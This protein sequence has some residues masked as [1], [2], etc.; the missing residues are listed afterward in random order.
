MSEG[1][2]PASAMAA[3]P[4]STT[5]SR[6][7]FSCWILCGVF[8]IPRTP[9]LITPPL[10]GFGLAAAGPTVVRAE[11]DRLAGDL[12]GRGGGRRSGGHLDVLGDRLTPTV[13]ERHQVLPR[14]GSIETK[15]QRDAQRGGPQ[16]A[17]LTDEAG[18]LELLGADAG[19]AQPAQGLGVGLAG[20]HR[21]V[22]GG[23]PLGRLGQAG[24]SLPGGRGV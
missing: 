19:L 7:D 14:L 12:V 1:S 2:T 11:I 6:S 9:T 22:V 16:V 8:P 21:R 4:D 17:D 10:V 23:R 24:D 20:A 5:R 3:R 13:A 18:V 15:G